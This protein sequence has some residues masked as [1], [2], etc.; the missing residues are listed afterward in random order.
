[1]RKIR[2]KK[3]IIILLLCLSGM[4]SVSYG[5]EVRVS[6]TFRMY[7][8]VTLP[9]IDSNEA[10]GGHY[11]VAT[12]T[13]RDNIPSERK[14]EGMLCTVLNDGSGI[15]RIYQLFRV[16]GNLVWGELIPK[17]SAPF[18]TMLYWN[19]VGWQKIPVGS[20]GQLLR[21]SSTNSPTWSDLE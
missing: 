18:G 13:D 17:E 7:P 2:K 21:L 4:L 8:W 1:M 5:Q 6:G 12:I 20:P 14:A 16:A 11:Q 9:V 19:G 10:L 15:T 3:Y